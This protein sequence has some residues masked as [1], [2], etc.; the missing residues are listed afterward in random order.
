MTLNEQIAFQSKEHAEAMRY[1]DNAKKTLKMAE[2]R[3]DGLYN[4]VK[5][6]QVACGTAYLGVLIAL[7]AWL[8]MKGVDIPV[9][10]NHTNIKFYL[11]NVGGLD[12]KMLGHLNSVYNILHLDGYY[13]KETSIKSIEAG[14]DRAYYI[15][16]KIKPDN[17]VDTPE[18]RV[19]R[20]RF[21]W[22]KLLISLAVTFRF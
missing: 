4:D 12:M 13:R 11:T 9:K 7:D 1:M 16:D 21:A 2:K 17:P 20:M 18:T 3:D 15:I 8:T 14:F 22:N 6:V 19:D 10:R 5:Y